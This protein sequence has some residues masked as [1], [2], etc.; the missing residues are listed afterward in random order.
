V[1]GKCDYVSLYKYPHYGVPGHNLHDKI[2]VEYEDSSHGFP[3]NCMQPLP[4]LPPAKVSKRGEEIYYA[5]YY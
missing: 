4:L 3:Y 1:L 2:E 5:F